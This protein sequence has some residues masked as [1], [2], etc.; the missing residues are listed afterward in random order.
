MNYTWQ[1]VVCNFSANQP[2]R[3]ISVNLS[4]SN[5]AGII[6]EHFYS[7]NLLQKLDLSNN[8]IHGTVPDFLGNMTSLKF[9]NLEGNNLSGAL[10]EELIRRF[11][12][13]SLALYF[14]GNPNLC[15]GN[16][17][18]QGIKEHSVAKYKPNL[19]VLVSAHVGGAAILVLLFILIIFRKKLFKRKKE[20]VYGI[21]NGEGTLSTMR[22]KSR[23]RRFNLYEILRV[24]NNFSRVIGK[25]G[26]GTVYHGVIDG[27]EVAVKMLSHSSSQGFKEFKAEAQILARVHHR[28]LTS[29]V[30]YCDEGDQLGLVYVFMAN[31]NLASHI[32]DGNPLYMTWE[33]RLRIA[34][35]ASQGLEYLHSGCKPPIIHRDIKPTN[36]L[37]DGN[38]Q[39]KLS[40][41]GLSKTFG[42]V[43]GDAD[44]EPTGVVAGTHGYLDPEYCNSQK[45]SEKS[46]VF[47]YGVV[48]LEI[49]TGQP[50]ISKSRDEFHIAKWV[51]NLL[52][53]QGDVK[54]IIDQRIQ[55]DEYDE[56]SVWKA[57]ELAMKCVST[58]SDKRPTMSE[59]V[60]ELNECLNMEKA[61]TGKIDA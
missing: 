3:I 24:T 5:L 19:I 49:I 44:Y 58:T 39:A 22:L 31:G 35:D 21:Q 4:S 42:N 6:S 16:C 56:N 55:A 37:L 60:I 43:V 10:P 33:Q 26:F 53:I 27:S 41:F 20:L 57:V 2:P 23:N 50:V 32:A 38:Y 40:D 51:S 47:S 34:L 61:R 8:S 1:G 48:L 17:T 12:E 9:L 36:I 11:K 29:L 59:V 28:N 7:L 45:L 52:N 30:G 13:G 18:E 15:I 54:L 25:G 46:D 14:G